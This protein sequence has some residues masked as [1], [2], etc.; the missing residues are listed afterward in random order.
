MLGKDVDYEACG[1]E[2]GGPLICGFVDWLITGLRQQPV[3]ELLFMAR[4]AE[5][6]HAVWL[7]RSADQGLSIPSRY[8]LISRRALQT[9]FY[10]PSNSQHNAF[11]ASRLRGLSGEQVC[12]SFQI[13]PQL[14]DEE[15]L[16]SR[17]FRM[18]LNSDALVM[19]WLDQLKPQLVL[20]AE[21]EREGMSRYLAATFKSGVVGLVD[22]GWHGSMQDLLSQA[23]TRLGL[24]KPVSLKGFYLGLL[25]NGLNR[26]GF[27][28]DAERPDNS[29]GVFSQLVYFIELFTAA[30]NPSLISV[31]AQPE[32][33]YQ[34][35]FANSATAA[36][37][38]RCFDSLRSGI[39]RFARNHRNSVGLHE[40]VKPVV[41]HGLLPSMELRN[42]LGALRLES[43]GSASTIPLLGSQSCL[44]RVWLAPNALR[45]APWPGAMWETAGP[46]ARKLAKVFAPVA[47]GKICRAIET[48]NRSGL[49]KST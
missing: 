24:D 17:H 14:L 26:E 28:C 21:Q 7:I 10:E 32:G 38:T 43:F 44:N 42:L 3:D 30:N 15:L 4:D 23:L 31:K 20:Q 40:A 9:A 18:G 27:C 2:I 1:Y 36:E 48:A 13:N 46:L 45:T 5:V 22:V 34:P 8:F 11:L 6:L 47:S 41:Q 39:L 25:R 12:A 49:L 37:Q 35:V 16:R 33:C 19:S 29:A